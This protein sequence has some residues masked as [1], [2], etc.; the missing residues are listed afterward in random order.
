MSVSIDLLAERIGRDPADVRRINL[1]TPEHMPYS[2]GCPTSTR[3]TTPI[4]EGSDYPE[5]FE[6]C[7]EHAD[8]PALVAEAGDAAQQASSSASG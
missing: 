4:Y 6:R 1:V 3:V 7:L 2:A 8:Y 5:V